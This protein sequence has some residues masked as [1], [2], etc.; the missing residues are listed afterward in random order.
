LPPRHWKTHFWLASATRLEFNYYWTLR[1]TH[2]WM[3]S[4]QEEGHWL[5]CNSSGPGK[6]I[7]L[8]TVLIIVLAAAIKHWAKAA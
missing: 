7:V 6:H 2:P 1:E 8:A 3:K 4:Q 5:E